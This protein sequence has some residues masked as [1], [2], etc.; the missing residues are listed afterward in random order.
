[1]L[2]GIVVLS[3]CA[4]RNVADGRTGV[5]TALPTVPVM[6]TADLVA[7]QKIQRR[8]DGVQDIAPLTAPAAAYTIGAG[9]ILAILVWGHPELSAATLN[10]QS[11]LISAAEQAA[12]AAAPQGF[13]VS[14]QGTIQF[15]FAA[16]LAVAGLTELQARDL[17]ARQLA[18]VINRPNVTLRVQAF[19]SQRIYVDG[20]VKAPGVQVINDI[21]MTLTEAINR[22]GGVTP[23]GDQSQLSIVRAG[24]RYRIDLPALVQH[25]EDPNRIMLRNG[26][27]LRVQALDESKVFVSGEVVTPKAL[28]MHSGR[29]SLNEAIGEAGGINPLTGDARRVFVVRR[30]QGPIELYQLDARDTGALAIAE[31]FELAPR[32]LVFVDAT[33][34]ANWHRTLSMMI[35]GSLTSAV[36]AGKQ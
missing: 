5:D 30:G 29:L 6:I 1:M 11:P 22:A 14:E 3:S 15:P 12:A 10:A 28:L 8:R 34:L 7:S 27:V 21:P 2:A 36:S 24:Q 32:D 31:S 26:D 17:L 35:P 18:P 4:T 33:G 9:D 23:T 13:V 25:G 20:E 19:R 16:N